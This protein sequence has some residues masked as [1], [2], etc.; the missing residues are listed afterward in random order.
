MRWRPWMWLSLSML[1]FLAA[2]YFWHMGDEWAAQKQKSSAPNGTNQAQPAG[3]PSKASSH[4]SVSPAK[5]PSQL[6]SQ[7][8]QVNSPPLRN[9]GNTNRV[10]PTAYRLTN[11]ATPLSRLTHSDKAILL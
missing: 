7:A 4:S 5:W 9:T 6:L 1:C 11:T 8:G 2:V 3:A 10:S